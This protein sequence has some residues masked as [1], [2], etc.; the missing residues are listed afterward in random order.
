MYSSVA[1]CEYVAYMVLIR[2]GEDSIQFAVDT[3]ISWCQEYTDSQMV[4]WKLNLSNHKDHMKCSG[5]SIDSKNVDEDNSCKCKE[6]DQPDECGEDYDNQSKDD[7]PR[8]VEWLHLYSFLFFL[9]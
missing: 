3:L 2:H 9:L 1:T 6:P 8:P 4:I 5:N 7:D